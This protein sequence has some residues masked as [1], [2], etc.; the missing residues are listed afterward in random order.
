MNY[1]SQPSDIAPRAAACRRTL[2]DLL[3]L[4]LPLLGLWLVFAGLGGYPSND[5]PFY[6][7]TAESFSRDFQITVFRQQGELTASALLHGLLGG[8]L[9]VVTGFSYRTLFLAVLLQLWCSGIALYAMART[10]PCGRSLA[11]MVS[12]TYLWTPLVLGHGFTF[13]TDGPA[14]AWLTAGLFCFH[15]ALRLNSS[16]WW[17]CGAMVSAATFWIRQT[18][19]LVVLYPLVTCGLLWLRGQRVLR[20][21]WGSL[22]V[23]V[24]VLLGFLL[25]ESELLTHGTLRRLDDAEPQAM[26]LQ[27]LK[28][29]A[30]AWYGCGLLIGLALLPLS[31]LMLSVIRRELPGLSRR[32]RL[33]VLGSLAAGCGSLLLPFVVTRGR[34]CLTSATGTFLQNAHFGPIFLSDTYETQRWDDMGGVMWPVAVWQ[35]LSLLAILTAGLLLAHVTLTALQ[36]RDKTTSAASALALAEG[37]GL[38]AIVPAFAVSLVLLISGI[39]DR[40]WMP[41]IP[42]CF[43]WLVVTQGERLSLCGRV[44]RVVGGFLVAGLLALSIVFVHDFLCWNGTCWKQAERWIASGLAPQD[45]DGGRSM[46]AWFRAA[47]DADTQPRPGDSSE[48]WSGYARFALASGP[49]AGWEVIDRLPWNSWATGQQHHVLVLQRISDQPPVPAPTE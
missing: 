36:W 21:S 33:A 39:L 29:I 42:V 41:L 3:L 6:G 12:L 11:L 23:P 8:M 17:V 19:V 13:M 37:W 48:W 35:C 40:Y 1:P 27:R 4:S 26:T 16:L 43:A 14:M 18:H 10:S 38:L 46:N 24:V 31:P 15:R 20:L 47:E 28:E 9:S 32:Q 7:R 44:P 30:I 5:D 2:C 45:F 22:S 25:F 34:A 49:R